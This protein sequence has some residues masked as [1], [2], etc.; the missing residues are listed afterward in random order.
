MPAIDTLGDL[1]PDAKIETVILEERKITIFFYINEYIYKS[2]RGTWITDSDYTGMLS[3]NLRQAMRKG[4]KKTV[5]NKNLAYASSHLETVKSITSNKEQ[6][7]KVMYKAVLENFDYAGI[8]DLSFSV[9]TEITK[10]DFA[11]TRGLKFNVANLDSLRGKKNKVL[12]MKRGN[13]MTESIGF[14]AGESFYTGPRTQLANG[15]WVT[16][17][18]RTAES[19][20]LTTRTIPNI[21]VADYRDI[22]DSSFLNG[23]SIAAPLSFKNSP[24]N[25]A[26]LT[27]FSDF[28]STRSK[29]G[30]LRFFFT[31]DYA[32]AYS[33]ESLYGGLFQ[34]MPDT[35]KDRVLLNSAIRSIVVSRKRA[36]LGT[37][38]E[39]TTEDILVTAGENLADRGFEEYDAPAG[40]LKEE[41]LN[42]QYGSLLLRSFSGVDRGTE[43]ISNGKYK[44]KVRATIL[45]GF[46]KFMDFQVRDITS[47][48]RMMEEYLAD[49]YKKN[50]KT[51]FAQNYDEKTDTYSERFISSLA[52]RH[53][54]ENLPYIRSLIAISENISF[55]SDRMTPSQQK[56]LL[57][58]LRSMLSPRTGTRPQAEDAFTFLKKIKDNLIYVMGVIDKNSAP[59]R[60]GKTGEFQSGIPRGGSFNIGRDFPSIIDLSTPF[61]HGLAFLSQTEL[62]DVEFPTGLKKI[63]G[64]SLVSRFVGESNKFF[65]SPNANVSISS[66]SGGT[67]SA[68]AQ[69]SSFS[70]LTPTSVRIGNIAYMMNSNK[71]SPQSGD[72]SIESL[73]SGDERRNYKKL[74]TQLRGSGQRGNTPPLPEAKPLEDLEFEMTANQGSINYSNDTKIAIENFLMSVDNAQL[75][76]KSPFDA[77][78]LKINSADPIDPIESDTELKIM[79]LDNLPSKAKFTNISEPDVEGSTVQTSQLDEQYSTVTSVAAKTT[80]TLDILDLRGTKSSISKSSFNSLP[81]HIKA[82]FSNGTSYGADLSEI[83]SDITAGYGD[84]YE[85]I[86]GS[87]VA[88]DTLDGY[89]RDSDGDP[90]VGSPKFSALTPQ[91]Y[92]ANAGRNILCR[93]RPY[94]NSPVGFS[95]SNTAQ[96]YNSYFVVSVPRSAATTNILQDQLNTAGTESE[97]GDLLATSPKANPVN[98]CTQIQE[99]KTIHQIYGIVRTITG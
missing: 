46:Y 35:L 48:V 72:L 16:G 1:L 22:Y 8:T 27:P 63:A 85:V 92:S 97:I 86:L 70:Y 44:Y 80:A 15:R 42:F 79:K 12:V 5:K 53:S 94:E 14:F 47:T 11:K 83:S 21:K 76:S 38:K 71:G 45:D 41:E 89:N 75:D 68:Q 37:A 3:I 73:S 30:V 66:T 77:K 91:K 82:M 18:T 52:K 19:Q 31:I 6:Y 33:M 61:D 88:V 57:N 84:R 65:N 25:G 28:D 90:I 10:E 7:S 29:S 64:S 58:T 69:P 87:M 54:F 17:R 99:E 78:I 98:S 43:G 36:D 23:I 24:P 95:R 59:A 51:G 55:L 93:L 34:K 9:N 4:G 74:L 32:M 96:I 67:M 40:A 81:N 26:T 2:G 60:I 56:K 49:S 13:V 62:L 39:I 50:P 20:F